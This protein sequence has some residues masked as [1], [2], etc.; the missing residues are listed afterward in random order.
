MKLVFCMWK[1]SNRSNTFNHFKWKWA[2]VLKVIQNSKSDFLHI[3]RLQQKEA[4]A[5]GISKILVGY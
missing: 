3:D 5:V 1:G 4:I 2:D